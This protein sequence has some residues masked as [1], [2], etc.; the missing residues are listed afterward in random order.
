M[1]THLIR[2]RIHIQS[3]FT[4]KE[5]DKHIVQHYLIWVEDNNPI[6]FDTALTGKNRVE[7]GGGGGGGGGK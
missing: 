2:Y 5:K 4:K 6:S 1:A 7:N 3:L